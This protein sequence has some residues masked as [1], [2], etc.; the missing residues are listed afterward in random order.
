MPRKGEHTKTQ[1]MRAGE[2]LF[3]RDGV[4][5]AL[6]RDIVAA[7]GQAND[8]AIHYHF[9]SRRGL[10]EAILT[11]HVGR[12]EAARRAAVAALSERSRLS[13][14]VR[15]IVEP[16]ATELRSDDGRDFLRIIAQLS[17]EA[18]GDASRLPIV[19][20]TAL[21][22]ELSLLERSLAASLPRVLV[23]ERV[24]MMI[25]ML[26]AALADRA[27]RLESGRRMS[28]GHD[29]YVADLVAMLTGALRARSIG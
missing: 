6:T 9:G 15:A 19:R 10:L 26:T 28:V 8:S 16:L 1:L 21:A 14:L 5:G 27:R 25:T 18:T 2:R 4:N 11:V 3:A 22:Q 24:A 7:A 12:M 17:A 29:A 23:R 13:T 20:D